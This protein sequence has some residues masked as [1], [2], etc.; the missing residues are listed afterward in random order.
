MKVSLSFFP[1]FKIYSCG[2]LTVEWKWILKKIL[3]LMNDSL[4][5]KNEKHKGWNYT[6]KSSH[7]T[8]ER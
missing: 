3:T 1:D 6:D 5:W 8:P 7:Q 4:G 2:K